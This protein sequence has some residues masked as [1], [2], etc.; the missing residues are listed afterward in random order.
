MIP[1]RTAPAGPSGKAQPGRE[2][3]RPGRRRKGAIGK[4]GRDGAALREADHDL[5]HV[6]SVLSSIPSHACRHCETTAKLANVRR[7]R[8]P[9]PVVDVAEAHLDALTHV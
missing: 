3:P 5:V 7:R 1:C 6:V 2:A 9:D 8:T 4:V